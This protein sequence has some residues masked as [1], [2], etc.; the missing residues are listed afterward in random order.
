VIDFHL[1]AA[2]SVTDAAAA[3]T[4]YEKLYNVFVLE[5]AHIPDSPRRILRLCRLVQVAGGIILRKQDG[6]RG[7]DMTRC[8]NRA[9]F[10]RFYARKKKI[11]S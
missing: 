6:R 9:K 1:H 5:F 7:C 4:G 11:T 10:Q 2:E 8:G 3:V